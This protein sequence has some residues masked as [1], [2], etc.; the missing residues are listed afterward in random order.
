MFYFLIKDSKINVN[1]DDKKKSIAEIKVFQ[2]FLSQ[3][4]FFDKEKM[5][6][7]KIAS[8]QLVFKKQVYFLFCLMLR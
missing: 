6:I 7:K 4:N 5:N 3:A 2:V 1:D 8:I